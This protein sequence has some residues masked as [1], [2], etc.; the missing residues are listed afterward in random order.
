MLC[1]VIR[2]AGLIPQV[3]ALGPRPSFGGGGGG[4]LLAWQAVASGPRRP[5]R[6]GDSAHLHRRILS[7]GNG[8]ACPRHC[9]CVPLHGAADVL[10]VEDQPGYVMLVYV[11]LVY[12]MLCYVLPVQD[13]PGVRTLTPRAEL[14]AYAHQAGAYSAGS[15]QEG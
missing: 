8:A 13:Q 14:L 10:P 15:V 11:M 1:H 4:W 5:G 2:P 12:V 9:A 7:G 6:A 3:I